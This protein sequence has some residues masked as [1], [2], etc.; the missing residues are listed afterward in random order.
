[1]MWAD[2]SFRVVDDTVDLFVFLRHGRESQD[3]EEH[4]QAA[5]DPRDDAQRHVAA[6]L[7]Q[8]GL[9]LKEDARPDDDTNDHADRG[10]QSVFSFQ[11]VFHNKFSRGRSP[12]TIGDTQLL[13]YT[14]VR[15]GASIR[16]LD[17]RF[18]HNALQR[19]AAS[20]ACQHGQ[21]DIMQGGGNQME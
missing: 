9:R 8:D 1:M 21:R 7:L 10:K 17:R 20:C 16:R 6:R 2:R 4:D 12:E 18:L 5:D 15:R 19:N 14:F 3:A 11:P 13:L